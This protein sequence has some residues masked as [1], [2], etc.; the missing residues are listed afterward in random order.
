M[1]VKKED[2]IG[3]RLKEEIVCIGCI[4]DNELVDVTQ[5]DIITESGSNTDV[6]VFCDRCKELILD[7]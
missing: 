7:N 5:D 1:E 2:I 6:M 3:Y 4:N